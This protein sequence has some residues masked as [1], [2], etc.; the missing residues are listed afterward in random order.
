MQTANM[1][2]FDFGSAVSTSSG[3]KGKLIEQWLNWSEHNNLKD[4]SR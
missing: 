3:V 4:V 1:A 2:G